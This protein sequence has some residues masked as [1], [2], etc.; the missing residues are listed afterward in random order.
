MAK[1]EY[2]LAHS[3]WICK[4]HIVFTP[5]YLH[6]LKFTEEVISLYIIDDGIGCKEIKKNM[7]LKCM[8]ER[9]QESGGKI[10]YSS[11]GEKG[12]NIHIEIPLA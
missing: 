8:E 6:S 7:G 2:S 5:K 3:K 9:V 4:Y 12:F 1:K 10:S 11:D